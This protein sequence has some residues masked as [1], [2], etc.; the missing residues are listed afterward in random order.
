MHWYDG[1]LIVNKRKA[2]GWTQAYVSSQT[3][4]SRN[5]IIAM[6]K[7]TFTGGIKYLRKYLDL[8][9]LRI[10]IVEENDGLPQ[11]E[12]LSELFGDDPF[13]GDK[14][15]IGDEPFTGDKSD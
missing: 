15:F 1:S 5:Q 11:L 8:L 12:E 3:G 7:G 13:T 6:E 10:N 9:N 4:L 2:N 14:P